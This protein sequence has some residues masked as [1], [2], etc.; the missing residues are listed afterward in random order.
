[1]E[2][3][4]CLCTVCIGESVETY[5]K[6][7]IPTYIRYCKNFNF[8]FFKIDK[9]GDHI[10]PH[11]AKHD[12]IPLLDK[13]EYIIFIDSDVYI[14]KNS[15]NILESLPKKDW[16]VAAWSQTD[17]YKNKGYLNKYKRWVNEYIQ[18]VNLKSLNNYNGSPYIN[19]GVLVLSQG[20][21][22]YNKELFPET[23]NLRIKDQNALN[24]AILSGFLKWVPLERKFNFNSDNKR[25]ENKEIYSNKT[26]F[27]H[28][29][30]AGSKKFQR[31]KNFKVKIKDKI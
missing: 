2:K 8:D 22:K 26:H 11:W 17:V 19:S 28:F 30:A 18:E 16:D 31:I 6:L 3:N 24:Y 1:M 12:V 7:T 25:K 5:S 29:W 9:I 14:K 13:Y 23:N 27:I 15:P 10:G 4:I 20:F 21:K